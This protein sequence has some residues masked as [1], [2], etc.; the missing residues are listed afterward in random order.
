MTVQKGD[1]RE[2][3]VRDP[4]FPIALMLLV[5]LGAWLGIFGPM[6]DGFTK[7]L[8]GWQTLIAA[9]VAAVAVIVAFK[10]TDRSLAHAESLETN[11]RRRKHAAVRAVLPLVLSQVIAYAE[12][13][14]RSLNELVSLCVG[15]TL[16]SGVTTE[17]LI[18]PLPSETLKSLADFIEYTDTT[19]VEVLES[20][21]AWIQIFDS[22]MRALVQ[23]NNDPARTWVVVRSEIKG[24]IVDAATIDAGAA[25]AFEYARR[26]RAAM[27]AELSW[28]VVIG[29]LRNMGLWDH[30]HPRVHQIVERRQ[31]RSTG[32]FDTLSAR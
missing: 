32:P 9:V 15:E 30:E 29:A 19:S 20:T 4:W 6:P 24:L 14:T 25:S 1:S 2:G 31:T 27:P 13:S 16:P 17:K 21:V 3:V 28:D 10:N 23:H 22:R 7:W 5:L 8:H 12:R 11:R 26:S 18:E